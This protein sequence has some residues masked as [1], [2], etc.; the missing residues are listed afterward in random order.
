MGTQ[1][2][3]VGWLRRAKNILFGTKLAPETE[4]YNVL[5]V[6]GCDLET[7]RRYRVSHQRE[8]L[9]LMGFTTTEVHYCSV[10]ETDAKIADVFVIYRCPITPE[11][12]A[13][14]QEAHRLNK[15]VFFDVDDLVIDTIYTNKLPVVQEMSPEEAAL[16]NDGIV[17]NGQTLKLCDAAIATTE[18]LAAELKKYV[19]QTYINRN[20]ASQEMV[21][22][23]QKISL[24]D[25]TENQI[26]IGYFSGSMTHNADFAEI[27]PV[28]AAVMGRH[29]NV[30]L[31]V[32]GDLEIPNELAKV[33][34]RIIKADR[35]DW[36]DLPQLI[37]SAD[38]N[39]APLEPTLFNEAKSENKWTEAALV[40]V[41]TIASNFGAFKTVIKN[42][43]TGLLCANT[44]EW[45]TALEGLISN[46]EVRLNI[47]QSAYTSALAEHTTLTTG[48]NLADI[49][50]G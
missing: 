7:L 11:V 9:E 18:R 12:E 4:H 39:L 19:P 17:R 15:R 40:K 25:K 1:T 5:F 42:G 24:N 27:L 38:I 26:I 41:P 10:K 47:G 50:F 35:V 33:C 36:H 32:V 22:L 3:N 16:F 20:V 45:E 44:A 2:D 46:Q 30:F 49:L 14:I 13:F 43:E 48:K 29:Q 37:A 8:Q 21:E 23:S 6:N 28:L 31:K 34:D